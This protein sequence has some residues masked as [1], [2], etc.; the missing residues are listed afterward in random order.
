MS[1]ATLRFR[2][3]DIPKAWK[4]G[5]PARTPTY[6]TD[7]TSLYSYDV[8]IGTTDEEGRKVLLEYTARGGGWV[9]ATTSKHVGYARPY[10]DETRRPEK[11]S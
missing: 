2:N 1:R 6:W 8:R 7:G 9:S 3:D 5:R 4:E 11:Q 10:A